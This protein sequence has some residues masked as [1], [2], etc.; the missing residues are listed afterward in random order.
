L[1]FICPILVQHGVVKE[2]DGDILACVCQTR[3]RLIAVYKFIQEQNPSMV[4]EKVFQNNVTGDEQREIKESPYF[5]MEDTLQ[6][7]FRLELKE[8]GLTPV[9]RIGIGVGEKKLGGDDL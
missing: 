4:Q 9:G 7:R 6:K 8:L 2:T 3:A 1:D 5:K